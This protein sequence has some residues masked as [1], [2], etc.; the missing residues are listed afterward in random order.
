MKIIN[1]ASSSSGNCYYVQF[2]NS[3]SLLLEAGLSL[4]EIKKKLLTYG[5]TLNDVDAVLITHNHKDHSKSALE[6]STKAFKEVYGNSYV[7]NEKNTLEPLKPRYLTSK[8][9]VIP[10]LV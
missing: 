9:L 7:A 2:D 8:I 4:K 1:L 10:F 6:L 3:A 5:K